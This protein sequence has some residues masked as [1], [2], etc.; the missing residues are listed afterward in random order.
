MHYTV[1]GRSVAINE[2]II[3]SML[4]LWYIVHSLLLEFEKCRAIKRDKKEKPIS[5]SSF[6]CPYSKGV[7]LYLLR[8]Q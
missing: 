8:H 7:E 3:S 4:A 1:L 2:C 6:L 5:V